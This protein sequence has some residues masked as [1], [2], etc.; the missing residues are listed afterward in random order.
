MVQLESALYRGVEKGT[1][2]SGGVRK[3][4]LFLVVEFIEGV[5][6]DDGKKII[7]E[8]E[9]D[10]NSSRVSDLKS[11]DQCI[12]YYVT[13]YNFPS[14]FSLSAAFLKGSIL[15]LKTVGKGKIYLKRG[16]AFAKLIEGGTSASGLLKEGDFFI[17]LTEQFI[18]VLGSDMELRALFDHR[19]PQE[20]VDSLSTLLKERTINNATAFFLQC[21]SNENSE[22]IIQNDVDLETKSPIQKLALA[23]K[24]VSKHYHLDPQMIGRRRIITL[25]AVI[26]IFIIFLWSVVFGYQ[27]RNE[28]LIGKKIANT[29]EIVTKKLSQAEEAAFL[30]LPESIDLLAQAKQEVQKLKKELGDKRNEIGEIEKMIQLKEN[31]IVKKEDKGY[32][33]FFDLTIASKNV[34]GEKVYLDNDI[35]SILDSK[36]KV[37]YLLSLVKKSLDKRSSIEISGAKLIAVDKDSVFFLKA[38]GI[39]Q[40]SQDG[41]AKKIISKDP[42]WG[43]INGFWIYNGNIYLLD[44]TAD[45]I[46][47]YVVAENG[48]S[49]KLSYFT[50]DKSSVTNPNSLAIDSSIYIGIDNSVL[51]FAG[52]ILE[53]FTTSWPEQNIHID[54]IFTSDDLDKVYVWNKTGSSLY[55]LNKNGTY[56]RQIKSSILAKASDFVIFNNIAYLLMK[57]KI[58]SIGLN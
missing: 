45:D 17:L 44:E 37:I 31:E 49:N 54:K 15:Y 5:K 41:K 1:G 24:K 55:V 22:E 34:S 16:D 57:E 13:Q 38:E 39:F 28:S 43:S 4:D 26:A 7:E 50:G 8:I 2:F 58:Y 33:E 51:K 35:L 18:E 9:K 40:I 21:K 52:G 12:S 27:R 56:E 30:D 53:D 36:N 47:K 11:F 10:D 46:Y 25:A 20:I 48:Y 29:K 32:E 6:T 23:F 19:N 14:S 42:N 3:G